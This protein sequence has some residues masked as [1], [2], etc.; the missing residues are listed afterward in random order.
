MQEEFVNR[1]FCE[2]TLNMGLY[3]VS[4]KRSHRLEQGWRLEGHEL[5]SE[6]EDLRFGFELL[7]EP[8]PD[9]GPEARFLVIEIEDEEEF[10][11]VYEPETSSLWI[12]PEILYQP[13]IEATVETAGG[14]SIHGAD[15]SLVINNGHGPAT[16]NLLTDP[17]GYVHFQIPHHNVER[18]HANK[19][20]YWPVLELNPGPHPTLICPDLPYP[21]NMLGWW[22]DAVSATNNVRQLGAGVKVG[23]VDTS[24]GAHPALK[25][26]QRV[27]AWDELANRCPYGTGHPHGTHV[28]GILSSRT[29]GPGYLGVAPAAELFAAEV[30]STRINQASVANAIRCLVED[31]GVHLINVSLGAPA[32]SR[33]LKD[34]IAEAADAGCVVFAAAGNSTNSVE[35]PASDAKTIGVTAM[36]MIGIYPNQ[37]SKSVSQFFEDNSVLH[38]KNYFFA[39]FSCTGSSID[40]CAP[41]IGIIATAPDGRAGG[42]A[43]EDGTSMASPVA[44]GVLA[45]KLSINPNLLNMAADA[46]RHN[47][48]KSHFLDSCTPQGWGRRFE[49]HGIPS[50]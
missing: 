25:H 44:C 49:G 28:C 38:S 15:V 34:V 9:E 46:N 8:A 12:E 29:K 21:G 50:V 11:G 19:Q 24:V 31:W 40:C 47:A 37:P 1:S 36:G 18:I 17:N 32:V 22:H 23:I 41:G 5:V 27:G 30:S 48:W 3:V 45:A 2:V 26:V 20:G 43:C 16:T 14:A 4:Q 35:H 13:A 7:T 39:E 10:D 33:G 42:W 6:L